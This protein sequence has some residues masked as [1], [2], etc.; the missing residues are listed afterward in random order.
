MNVRNLTDLEI[1]TLK[2]QGCFSDNWKD[3]QVAEPFRCDWIRNVSFRGSIRIGSFQKAENQPDRPMGVYNSEICNCTLGDR[4]FIAGVSRLQ[5]YDVGDDATIR[6]VGTLAVEGVSSF[7]NGTELEILNEGGG[8]VVKIYDR[9]TAQIAYFLAIYRHRPK[10][11]ERLNAL[12][13]AYV[14]TKT[15]PR[16]SIGDGAV[17]VNCQTLKNVCVGSHATI[18]GATWLQNGTIVS[19]AD[20]RTTVGGGVYAKNFIIQSGSS[21]DS[22][23]I[24]T[25]VF[26]GQAV[27]IGKQYSAE[28]SAFFANC[29]GFHGEA[30]S[31]F[32]GPYT[33]TH[34]KSTLLIAGLFSF[35]NAG[36][37][38]NQSNHMYKLG[39]NHQGI[40]QRGSKTGSFSYLLWP[41]VV[42]PFSVVIGKHYTNF[43]VSDLP[44]SY[45]NE[46]EGKSLL[47]PAMNLFTVGTRR[48][49]QK[50]PARDRRKGSEILD[51]IH[52]DFLNPYMMGKVVKATQILQTLYDNASKE[53]EYVQYNGVAVK[54]LMLKTCRKYYEIAIKISLGEGFVN[55]LSELPDSCTPS[56]IKNCL[57]Q[58]SGASASDWL[59]VCGLLAPSSAIE[60]L[61]SAIETQQIDSLDGILD[62]LKKTYDQYDAHKWDWYCRFIENHYGA[63]LDRLTKEQYSQIAS[64]WKTNR[65]KL[66]NLIIQDALKEFDKSARIG[67]GLDGDDAAKEGDF[68]QV[69]GNKDSN[70]FIKELQKEIATVEQKAAE[71]LNRLQRFP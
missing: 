64:D 57:S 34:H 17:I 26:V 63:P 10:L 36:S 32:A 43:D 58:K 42:G 29:E 5:S 37:G 40:L 33:V 51:L 46:E 15:Q 48:D 8:R 61:L 65:I 6:N 3:V 52:F 19:D 2:N 11:I 20:S 1:T 13:D 23:A 4:V 27:K 39:P 49:S 45:I 59:D 55:R 70:S 44:F 31:I 28:N 54:R 12:I 18:E 38:S 7:G 9:L 60:E 67:Y 62:D 71:I 69:R 22:S 68:E 66:N 41:C 35:Y 25:H 14:K 53:A 21:V 47:T 24:L 30:C 16:G 56:D 50:W